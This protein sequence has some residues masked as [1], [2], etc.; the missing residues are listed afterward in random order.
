[1]L[2]KL[3]T[4]ELIKKSADEYKQASGTEMIPVAFNVENVRHQ[5]SSALNIHTDYIMVKE[6]GLSLDTP[7]SYSVDA[8]GDNYV[9][10]QNADNVDGESFETEAGF[11][12]WRED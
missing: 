12:Y 5:L 9:V 3:T 2:N 7:E 6:S 11:V 1:M 10:A 8:D 4:A